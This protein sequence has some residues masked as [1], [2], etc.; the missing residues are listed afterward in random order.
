MAS[1]VKS[2][3]YDAMNTSDTSAK[4]YY[5]IKFVLDP[6]TLQD[7]T[8]FKVQIISAGGLVIKAQYLSCMQENTNCYL[9]QKN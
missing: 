3:K 7:D 2:V 1:L 4:G 9:E 5:G 8:I 6:Y